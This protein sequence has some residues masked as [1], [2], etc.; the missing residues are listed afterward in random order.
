MWQTIVPITNHRHGIMVSQQIPYGVRLLLPLRRV[1][2]GVIVITLFFLFVA[3]VS[4]HL[5]C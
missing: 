4:L 3:S 2:Y 1:S 5:G